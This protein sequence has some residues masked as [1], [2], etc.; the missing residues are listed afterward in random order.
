V[1]TGRRITVRSPQ[2]LRP[3]PATDFGAREAATHFFAGER[4]LVPLAE[5]NVVSR[6]RSHDENVDGHVLAEKKNEV[7]YLS[8]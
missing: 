6:G 8:A 7:N 3:L 1:T 2:R 4:L 5:I